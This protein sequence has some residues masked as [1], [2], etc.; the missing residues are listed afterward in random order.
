MINFSKERFDEIRYNYNQWWNHKID[1]PIAGLVVE[2]RYLNGLEPIAPLLTQ[3]NCT[4]LTYSPEQI[5]DRIVYEMSKNEYYG[6]AFP[7]FN[8]SCF[9]PGI[10][11]AFLGACIDNSTGNVWFHPEEKKHISELSFKY[12]PQNKWLLRIKAICAA[13]VDRFE[14]K[15]LVGMVD[16]GG[17]MD[18]LSTFRPSDQLLLDLYDEPYEVKRLC[19]EIHELWLSFH[20]ELNSIIGKNG[21]T[22]WSGILSDQTSYII[23]SDFTYMISP[24]AFKEFVLDEVVKTCKCLN[25]SIWHLDGVG[26][27]PHLD[28]LLNINDLDGI[29]WVPG[30]GMPP[31]EEWLDIYSKIAQAGKLIQVYQEDFDAT[32]Q[33]IEHIGLPGLIQN[34][35]V[36][37]KL[38]KK[39]EMLSKMKRLNSSV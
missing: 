34:L 13:L 32:I 2:E 16:L 18:I 33:I 15:A 37:C 38:N 27:L 1:R 12:D 24:D 21:Y 9:G 39:E 28:M 29:Q 19:W 14:D 17:V 20:N 5:A 23:Q 35:T 22:D 8:M 10:V 31:C 3:A 26:E 4:D 7:F 6:D 30:V 11:A 36:Y 25:H